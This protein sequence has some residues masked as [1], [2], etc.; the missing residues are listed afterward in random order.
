MKLKRII[1]L[2]ILA[3]TIFSL[4][5]SAVEDKTKE[6]NEVEGKTVRRIRENI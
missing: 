3:L 1:I 4:F 2:I 6:R 5:V